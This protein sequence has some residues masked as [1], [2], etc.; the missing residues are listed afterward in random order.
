LSFL[1]VNAFRSVKDAILSGAWWCRPVIPALKG[2]RQED[3]ELET[4]LNS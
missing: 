1:E 3:G 4:S 2:L